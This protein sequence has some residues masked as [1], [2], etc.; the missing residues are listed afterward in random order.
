MAQPNPP[1]RILGTAPKSYNGKGDT[2]IAFWNSLENYFTVNAT[3]FDTNAKKVLLALTYFKQGTQAED[4]ASDHIA[5]IL[6]GNPVNYGMWQDF[7]DAF[8]AQFIPL[9]TQNEAIQSIHN[10]PQRNWEF[11]KW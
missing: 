3:T 4:W 5:T 1:P 6:A 8:K 10:T 9:E 11:G 7:R 2:A